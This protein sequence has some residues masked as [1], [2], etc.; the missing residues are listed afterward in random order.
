ML[1]T[2]SKFEG[3]WRALHISFHVFLISS[4]LMFPPNRQE[5][6]SR[7]LYEPAVMEKHQ[8]MGEA[9]SLQTGL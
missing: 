6:I 2:P 8:W 4:L 9:F 1:S 3:R 7:H 5:N